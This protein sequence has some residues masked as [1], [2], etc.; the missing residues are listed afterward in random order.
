MVSRRIREHVASHNWFAVGVD[1]AIVVAGVFLGM[2]VNNWNQARV[3]NEQARDYR[4][5]LISELDFNARQYSEQAHYFRQVRANGIA[6]VAALDDPSVPAADLLIYAYQLSQMDEA[7]PKAYIYKEMAASG[8]VS[9][10]GDEQ[11]Q[12]IASDYYLNIDAATPTMVRMSPYRELVRALIPVS[13]QTLI[14]RRCGD[15]MVTYKGRIV[16]LS[17]VDD[18]HLALDS[19]LAAAAAREIREW[20][21]MH[22]EMTRYVALTQERIDTIDLNR[23]LTA[24]FMK[25]L[26]KVH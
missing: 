25:R 10:L 9:R 2:Q 12:D 14:R 17:L 24:E 3:E 19:P 23:E 21:G 15:R 8:L 13:V 22:R 11:I 6:A 20:P 4:R 18:C 16:G 1:L 5:R 7:P 26:A